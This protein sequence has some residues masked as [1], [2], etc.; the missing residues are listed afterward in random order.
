VL[1]GHKII[2][3]QRKEVLKLTSSQARGHQI[4]SSVCTVAGVQTFD[5]G[6]Q[7]VDDICWLLSFATQSSVQAYA[8]AA[9]KKKTFRG[10]TGVC[11]Q[12][13][14]A[15]GSG[16]GK[17]SDFIVLTWPYYRQLNTT[18]PIS[19]F[20]HM[21]DASD[22]TDGFLETK[23]TTGMQCLE[24]IKSYFAQSEGAKH[25]IREERSGR[26]VNARNKEL[27]FE[28]LLKLTLGEI[29]MSLPSSFEKIKR[30]RNAL[31]Y[32]ANIAAI[33]PVSR[34]LQEL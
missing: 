18:G 7:L 14:P 21:I 13:R 2:I 23:I 12:W 24:S 4:D 32:C 6:I 9:A 33:T 20:I 22:V 15:F 31:I 1:D 19:A 8:H 11:N 16:I 17:L 10:V 30:L 27:T 25:G 5:E 29:G 26:F 28:E 34:P 3:K